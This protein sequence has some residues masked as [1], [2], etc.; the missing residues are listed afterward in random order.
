MTTEIVKS[1]S[2]LHK[3]LYSHELVDLPIVGFL[4]GEADVIYQPQSEEEVLEILKIAKEKKKPIVP[5]GV[6]TSSY[7]GTLPVKGGITVDFT[8]M[9]GFIIDEDNMVV[10]C[11]PGAVWWDI[12]KELNK[13]GL[14][15]R[16]YPTSA[17][18]STVGGWI[19]QNGWGVGS[20]KYGGIA[21]NVV[22]LRVADFNGVR[23]VEGEE[24]KYYIGLEG[25]TG[26]ITRAWIK[27]KEKEDMKFYGFHVSAE[28]ANKIV[29]KGDHYAALFMDAGYVK[30]KNQSFGTDMPEKDTLLVATTEKLDGDESLGEELWDVRFYPMKV[31][32]LGPGLIAAEN[33]VPSTA[34]P[35][36]L[37][38]IDEKIKKL[39][40]SEIWYIKGGRGAIL[41]YIPVD[42][43]KLIEYAMS[44]R[45]SLKA[46]K[47]AK[48][49][50]GVA[51]STG[52]YLAY[53]AP[54]VFGSNY[55][56]IKNYKKKIDPD[57]LLNP[58]KVFPPGL[59]SLPGLIPFGVRLGVRV[60]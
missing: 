54:S 49:M 18:S 58:C 27:V 38:S 47:L 59:S 20:L 22:K 11:A 45:Y 19:A 9:D 57:N 10:E 7:G 28:E 31:R 5:R 37:K 6:A 12:E 48:K 17:L 39:H 25:T 29:F 41:T 24:L 44:W 56:E 2:K 55:E 30:M 33:I 35:A 34:I 1:E 53:E 43:R 52:L 13:K 8:R 32:K 42:E 4:L 15:L 36:Y 60:L 50:G 16:A 26:L 23:E 14:T 21:D 40:G 46:L 3:V 51:Y